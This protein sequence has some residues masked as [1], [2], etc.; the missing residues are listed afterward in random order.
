[1]AGLFEELKRRNVVRVGVAY[2]VISWVLV[3]VS[4][5]IAPM[6]A[7]PDW[8]PRLVLFVLI[9]GLPVALFLSWAYELTPEGVKKTHE[10][11]ADA[12]ITHSTGRKL[13][14]MIIG[15]LVVAVAFLVYDRTSGPPA[16]TAPPAVEAEPAAEGPK[17]IAVLPFADMSPDQSQEY[18]ADGISEELLN[19]LV[20][21]EGL[22]V[23]SRTSSFSFKGKDTPIPEIAAALNVDHILE[24]SVR[25]QGNRVRITAQLIDVKT[26]SHLW[27]ASF[28]REL[29]D[30]FAIQDEIAAAIVAALKV[31]LIGEAGPLVEASTQNMEAYNLYLRG[32]HQL[33]LRTPQSFEAAI[34]VL[35]QA[36]ALDP[37][38]ADAY[39]TLSRVFYVAPRYSPDIPFAEAAER[40]RAAARTAIQLAPDDPKAL[41]TSAMAKLVLDW[42]FEGAE[43][44][45]KR[46]VALS[47]NDSELHNFY[48]DYLRNVFDFEKAIEIEGRAAELDP[49]F[50]VNWTDLGFTYQLAGE[51]DNAVAAYERALAIDPRRDSALE[52]LV[53]TYWHAGRIDEAKRALANLIAAY[54]DSFHPAYYRPVFAIL[55]GDNDRASQLIADFMAFPGVRESNPVSI[56]ELYYLAGDVDQTV[57]WLESAY[58]A[59]SY[60]LL[61][62]FAVTDPRNPP[63]D[64]R[65][66]EIFERPGL[67]KL[68]DLR[69]RNLGLDTAQ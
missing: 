14:R 18:F 22:R 30:I 51:Y 40:G 15:A 52:G 31:A 29:D 63:D 26:D 10:V 16:P 57:T 42:D 33:A 12:S 50:P 39:S 65:I 61:G 53:L 34:D 23:S 45:F 38:F 24:G 21:V 13:D 64:P 43:M 9:I 1:M 59:R 11:D 20:R 32:L 46:A 55:D 36:I 2:L 19:V 54:P 27:S 41:T 5:T 58:E 66:L 48:G 35:E 67:K 62:Q 25:S 28:D 4:D 8:A 44:D 7:L 17:T 56:A 37:D 68:M 47:P 69:R 60:E 49:L 3:E 6:M